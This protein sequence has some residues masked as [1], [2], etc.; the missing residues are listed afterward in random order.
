MIT[1]KQIKRLFKN[2]QKTLYDGLWFSGHEGDG[3][4]KEWWDN[5]ILYIHCFYKKNRREGEY[6]EWY[7]NGQLFEHS[8]YKDN[9]IIRRLK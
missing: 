3:E 6:K 9:R 7:S 8:F 2:P 1:K 4:Y 5:G